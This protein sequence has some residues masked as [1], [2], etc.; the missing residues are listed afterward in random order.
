MYIPIK[1]GI[2]VGPPPSHLPPKLYSETSI[3]RTLNPGPEIN[4]LYFPI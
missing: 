2:Y 4:V 1:G 3:K